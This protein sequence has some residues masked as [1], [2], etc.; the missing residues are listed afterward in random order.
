L[1]E[2]DPLS[3]NQHA[4]VN[5]ILKG[6]RH[7]LDLINEVLDIAR[8][9]SGRLQ[10]SPEPVRMTEAI[11]EALDLILLDLHLPD[12]PGVEVLRHL[13]ADEETRNVPV[14]VISADA[15]PGQIERLRAAGVLAYLTK[16][17]DV[18]EFLALMGEFLHEER[19]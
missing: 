5:R 6:G 13:R 4:N 19:P 12:L 10:L 15:T 1:L 14:I 9:E 18:A 11:R 16:P 8:I 17:L 7:L 2:M 3:P